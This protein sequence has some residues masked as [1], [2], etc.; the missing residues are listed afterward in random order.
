MFFDVKDKLKHDLF[1]FFEHFKQINN[2]IRAQNNVLIQVII[3]NNTYIE[4][5]KFL[6]YQKSICEFD[7]K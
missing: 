1:R 3:N 6:N 4:V 2:C 7:E 5:K